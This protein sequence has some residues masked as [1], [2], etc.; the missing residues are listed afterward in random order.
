MRRREFITF[1][2]AVAASPA[3]AEPGVSASPALLEAVAALGGVEEGRGRGLIHVLYAPWCHLTPSL[4]ADTR[5]LL[6]RV[7]FRWA[8][9]SG[10]QPE[11]RIGTERLLASPRPGMIERSFVPI[12]PSTFSGP[13]PLADAQDAAVAAMEPIF[14]RDVGLGI[15]TPTLFFDRGGDRARVVRGAPDYPVLETMAA[16]AS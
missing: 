13:T 16:L 7:R 12:A 4:Y 3:V 5:A 11:G 10:G 1:A 9:F 6:E 8:P 14:A 2:L 15:V